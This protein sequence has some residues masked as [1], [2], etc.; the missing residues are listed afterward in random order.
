MIRLRLAGKTPGTTQL[1][2]GL[3]EGNIKKMKQ[4]QPVSMD[5]TDMGLP[6]VTIGIFYGRDERAMMA[7]LQEFIGPETKI[8]ID[9]KTNMKE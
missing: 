3:T 2:F 9:P 1:L 4:G 7:E 6:G 8:H 5:L